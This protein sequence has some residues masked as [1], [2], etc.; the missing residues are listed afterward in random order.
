MGWWVGE[1]QRHSLD[2]PPNPGTDAAHTSIKII[3]LDVYLQSIRE[4]CRG[5]ALGFGCTLAVSSP[6]LTTQKQTW[7]QHP[8][9][10][11]ALRTM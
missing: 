9:R 7:G 5:V 11:Q 10:G 3:D 1:F 2:F 8:P 6:T 4:R